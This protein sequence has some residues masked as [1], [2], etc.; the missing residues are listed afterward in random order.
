MTSAKYVIDSSRDFEI[1]SNVEAQIPIP[2]SIRFA[3]FSIAP[4][5][6]FALPFPNLSK[7]VAIALHPIEIDSAKLFIA[8]VC[9][10]I[11]S[12]CYAASAAVCSSS[13]VPGAG[14][15]VSQGAV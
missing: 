12:V 3:K 15:S 14:T 9:S 6:V 11:L 4:I 13:S 5:S 1:E 2:C 8:L 7:E 10:F